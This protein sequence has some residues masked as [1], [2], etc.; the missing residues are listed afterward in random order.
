MNYSPS[1]TPPPGAPFIVSNLEVTTRTA[2]ALTITWTVSGVIDRF[3]VVYTYAVNGC[4]ASGGP[5]TDTPDSS[6]GS[7]TLRELSANSRYT[8][9]IRARNNA[10]STVTSTT[11]G[12]LTAGMYVGTYSSLTCMLQLEKLVTC[13]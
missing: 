4:S 13:A 11:A 9:T 1:P 3:E 7:H 2:T 12:T 6:T 8:I 10:V 5:L